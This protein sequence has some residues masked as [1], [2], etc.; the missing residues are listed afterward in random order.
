MNLQQLQNRLGQLRAQGVHPETPVFI[1]HQH[2]EYSMS[3]TVTDVDQEQE[4]IIIGAWP[5]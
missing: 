5:D 4:G 3:E 1:G 2:G